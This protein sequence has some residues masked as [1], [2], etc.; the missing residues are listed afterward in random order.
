MGFQEG[1]QLGLQLDGEPYTQDHAGK[2]THLF[3]ESSPDPPYDEEYH[4]AND[5]H[6]QDI[7]PDFL[8]KDSSPRQGDCQARDGMFLFSTISCVRKQAEG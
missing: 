7:H 6:I 3:K 4:R 1:G 5:N 2:G 8:T